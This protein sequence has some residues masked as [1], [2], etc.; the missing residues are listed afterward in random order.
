MDEDRRHS[1]FNINHD[2]VHNARAIDTESR[3]QR[4]TPTQHLEQT[5]ELTGSSMSNTEN[6]EKAK[7]GSNDV[8][9]EE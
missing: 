5:K 4:P 9:F 2:L 6:G 1:I 3:K 7:D 8:H